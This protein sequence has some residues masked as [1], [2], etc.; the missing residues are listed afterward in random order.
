MN[1]HH[2]DVIKNVGGILFLFAILF[3]AYFAFA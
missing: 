1:K 2:K 3:L